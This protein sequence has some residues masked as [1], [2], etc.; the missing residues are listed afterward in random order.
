MKCDVSSRVLG[1]F[2]VGVPFHLTRRVCTFGKKKQKLMTG[3]RAA[4]ALR[5]RR[6]QNFAKVVI[7]HDC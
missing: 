4:R 3:A 5:E 7:L 2:A 6:K 1:G